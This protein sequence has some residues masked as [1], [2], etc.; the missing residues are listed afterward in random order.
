MRTRRHRDHGGEGQS[1]THAFRAPGGAY[2]FSRAAAIR[3]GSDF[4]TPPPER[5]RAPMAG[6]GLK[7]TQTQAISLPAESWGRFQNSATGEG[8]RLPAAGPR[9]QTHVFPFLLRIGADF[10][11]RP[12]AAG[13][14]KEW[15]T[16]PRMGLADPVN[17]QAT[18]SQGASAS[19]RNL[20]RM[21]HRKL[22]PTRGRQAGAKDAPYDR[23]GI[24]SCPFRPAAWQAW[25]AAR[26][27]SRPARTRW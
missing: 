4:E 7:S 15:I 3:I 18:R 20:P 23:T 13:P 21:G 19:R 10:K 25:R 27:S 24:T 12:R 14:E 5:E 2:V 6:G 1:D 26:T 17:A 22:Y 9:T 11:R 8:E 16:C